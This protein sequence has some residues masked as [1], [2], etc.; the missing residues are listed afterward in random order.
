MISFRLIQ[1]NIRLKSS[2][3]VETALFQCIL[4]LLCVLREYAK[5]NFIVVGECVKSVHGDYIWRF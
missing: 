3:L 5:K 4:N 1:D 2:D